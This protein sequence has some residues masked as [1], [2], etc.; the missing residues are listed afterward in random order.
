MSAI[1]LTKAIFVDFTPKIED[2]KESK[3]VQHWNGTNNIECLK[4]RP[5]GVHHDIVLGPISSGPGYCSASLSPSLCTYS[6]HEER[7]KR[8]LFASLCTYNEREKCEI[9]TF[10][11][12]LCTYKERE[13]CEK[14]TFCF[15]LCTYRER[16]SADFREKILS[17]AELDK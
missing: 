7:E 8:I 12:T 15:S 1:V 9:R 2:L 14:C 16:K 13:K 10:F 5:R 4:E 6:E 3:N 17:P 11:F